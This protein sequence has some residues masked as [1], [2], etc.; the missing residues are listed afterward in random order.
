MVKMIGFGTSTA[1][2]CCGGDISNSYSDRSETWDGTSW[3]EGNNLNQ[4]RNEVAA[5]SGTTTAGLV[6]GGG[7]NVAT[8]EEWLK[9]GQ[10]TVSFTVS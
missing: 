4:A 3:S 2:I 5:V 10:V 8:T 1:A 9:P 6:F 7:S